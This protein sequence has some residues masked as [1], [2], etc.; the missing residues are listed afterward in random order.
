MND[1]INDHAHGTYITNSEIK[2][3]TLMLKS[4]LCDYSDVYI[5]LKRMITVAELQ[6][7]LQPQIIQIKK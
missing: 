3:N 6:L 5:L 7:Q 2:I 1:Q 4:N